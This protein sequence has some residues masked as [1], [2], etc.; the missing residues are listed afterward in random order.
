MTYDLGIIGLAAMELVQAG[1]LF[2]MIATAFGNYKK[3]PSA[4]LVIFAFAFLMLFFQGVLQLIVSTYLVLDIVLPQGAMFL[5][6][7]ITF[8]VI[9]V[10]LL[11]YAVISPLFSSHRKKLAIALVIIVGLTAFL[12]IYLVLEGPQYAALK[13]FQ[14]T[15]HSFF[16]EAIIIGGLT[17]IAAVSYQAWSK[18]KVPMVLSFFVAMGAWLL[19]HLA[20]SY[21]ALFSGE[22]AG[23]MALAGQIFKTIALLLLAYYV[24]S[25]LRRPGF[26]K[27]E[28]TFS[29]VA[30]ILSYIVAAGF[31]GFI[32]FSGATLP[33]ALNISTVGSDA[34]AT[35]QV[36]RNESYMNFAKEELFKGQAR[37]KLVLQLLPLGQYDSTDSELHELD[38]RIYSAESYLGLANDAGVNPSK[39][40]ELV[41]GVEYYK[42]YSKALK[43]LNAGLRQEKGLE[44]S[45]V[46]S[47][48]FE[49]RRNYALQ[50]QKKLGELKAGAGSFGDYVINFMKEHQDYAK[51][52]SIFLDTN[53]TLIGMNS[54][55]S[56]FGDAEKQARALVQDAERL[57]AI[58]R[59]G[60]LNLGN[61]SLSAGEQGQASSLEETL[62]K[63]VERASSAEAVR[64]LAGGLVGKCGPEDDACRINAMYDY[65]TNQIKY[66]KDPVSFDYLSEATETILTKAGDCEDKSILLAGMLKVIGER[67]KLVLLTRPDTGRGHVFVT[68]RIDDLN[69]FAQYAPKGARPYYLPKDE[70]YWIALETTAQGAYAG[71]E[72]KTVIE[73]CDSFKCKEVD[74]G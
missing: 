12:G 60:I 57:K 18:T 68:I 49:E 74:L 38:L 41:K 45:L 36:V 17:I 47:Q 25:T 71:Y 20:N 5:V 13:A 44:E 46:Q 52:K 29:R 54:L 37:V 33:T 64:T 16:A 31:I 58:T 8:E 53:A 26:I 69:E 48:A 19:C 72:D 32:I 23:T 42:E 43:A 3:N 51:D 24:A 34:L 2:V 55:E 59:A 1:I 73:Q 39:I 15:W 62:K 11:L 9:A 66:V 35:Q 67:P 22:L 6:A 4:N 65:A 14:P 40:D 28:L 30:N 7:G 10:L 63:K 70:K 56:A 61:V 21:N 27:Q 50:I